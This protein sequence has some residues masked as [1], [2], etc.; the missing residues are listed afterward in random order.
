MFKENKNY[1][2]QELLKPENKLELEQ[3]V[4]AN[5]SDELER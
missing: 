5:P 2:R 4:N 1:D 3:L